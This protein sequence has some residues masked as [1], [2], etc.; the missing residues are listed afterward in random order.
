MFPKPSR[1]HNQQRSGDEVKCGRIE[2]SLSETSVG[3]LPSS[4]GTNESEELELSPRLA[5]RT[6]AIKR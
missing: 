5:I 4:G 1:R 2:R 6:N 3:K